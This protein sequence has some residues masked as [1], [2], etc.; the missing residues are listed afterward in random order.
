MIKKKTLSEAIPGQ[1]QTI[2]DNIGQGTASRL[3]LQ[4]SYLPTL[5]DGVKTVDADEVP[6]MKPSSNC[7]FIISTGASSTNMPVALGTILNVNRVTGDG[8]LYV[9][10]I[11]FGGGSTYIRTGMIS[12][13]RETKDF[14][15]WKKL[16]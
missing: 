11:N 12:A 1:I 9:T 8:S 3:G 6:L 2:R 10:Q 16:Y 14:Q 7:A 4:Y 15:D 5:E 13:D